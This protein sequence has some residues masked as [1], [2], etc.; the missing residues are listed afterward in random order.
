MAGGAVAATTVASP[1]A[2]KSARR[3]AR[4]NIIFILA[5]DLGYADLS[6]YGRPDRVEAEQNR[7]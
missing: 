3:S 2:A 1:A 7:A 4:P 5:D 6:C